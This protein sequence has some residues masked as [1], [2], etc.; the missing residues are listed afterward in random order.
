MKEGR[1]KVSTRVL[2]KEGRKKKEIKRKKKS[3]RKGTYKRGKKKVKGK[4]K[5]K[6]ERK[7]TYKR[8]KKK[9][10]KKEA[11]EENV[12][13]FQKQNC[14]EEISEGISRRI[15]KKRNKIKINHPYANK[16]NH[17]V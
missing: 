11:N 15:S 7:G 3:E 1:K 12:D 2:K 9:E 10:R 6:S 16:G 5:K 8:G 14:Q 4:E 13:N 17:Q